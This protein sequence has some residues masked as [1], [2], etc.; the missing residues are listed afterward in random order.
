MKKIVII[1]T[2]LLLAT[3]LYA[4]EKRIEDST[5]NRISEANRYL[6]VMPPKYMLIDFVSKMSAQI[7]EEQ[8][9]TFN[10]LMIKNMDLDRF[11]LIIRD[12][13]VKHFTAEELA[14]LADF[15]SSPLGRSAMSKFGDYMAEAMPQ[16]QS[17]M[18][19]AAQKTQ[20]QMKK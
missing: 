2:V 6:S 19:E 9:K 5:A 7:P 15:Y 4:K 17:I 3:Q 18:I 14:A 8:Q 10:D 12:S 13:M 16:I 20:K 11:S 1:L